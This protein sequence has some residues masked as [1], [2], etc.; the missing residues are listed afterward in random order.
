MTKPSKKQALILEFMEY[1][2]KE[3]GYPPTYQEIGDALDKTK[4]TIFKSM[5]CLE[6]KG[7]VDMGSGKSRTLKLLKGVENGNN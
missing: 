2:I 4:S 5:V 3:N 1:F 7:Y 6:K